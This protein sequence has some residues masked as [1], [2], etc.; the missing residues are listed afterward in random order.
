MVIIEEVITEAHTEEWEVWK[1]GCLKDAP[2]GPSL[3]VLC[4]PLLSTLGLVTI[5]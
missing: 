4:G 3:P 2:Q 5:L 1:G